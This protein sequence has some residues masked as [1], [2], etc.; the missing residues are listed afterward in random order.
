MNIALH[1]ST[2]G[3]YIISSHPS[4]TFLLTDFIYLHECYTSEDLFSKIDECSRLSKRYLLCV[5]SHPYFRYKCKFCN[6]LVNG[7]TQH[8]GLILITSVCNHTCS[9][10]HYKPNKFVRSKIKSSFHATNKIAEF[11]TQFRSQ[12]EIPISLSDYTLY[13]AAQQN[14]L[15]TKNDN[16]LKY[17]Y[18]RSFVEQFRYDDDHNN[19]IYEEDVID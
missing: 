1:S 18:I 15:D 13:R 16:L 14:R 11:I 19:V 12:T 8:D 10:E 6:A 7:I 4:Q 5:K 2:E 9:E 3:A 17:K